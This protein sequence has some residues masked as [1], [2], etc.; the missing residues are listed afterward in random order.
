MPRKRL[1]RTKEFS[2]HVT[3]RSV[4]Q[5]FYPQ[6]YMPEI[7]AMACDLLKIITWC[8][9]VRVHA[10]VLMNNHYHLLIST[11]D[12]NLDDAMR[13]FQSKFSHTLSKTFDCQAL[14]FGTR[15]KSTLVD[16]PNYY[17]NV[18]R[19]IFQNPVR[20][21][22]VK[23]VE[24]YPWSN[25]HGLYG[26]AKLEIP[27]YSQLNLDGMIPSRETNAELEWLN[28]VLI[29]SEVEKIK[30]GLSKSIFRLGLR[31]KASRS[32]RIRPS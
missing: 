25:L 2:Y 6:E 23:S 15:Y 22:I 17:A 21:K 30:N 4:D 12:E 5:T 13:Y 1:I 20:A 31:T 18:Y 32:L 29:D 14:C 19:Y 11:P 9:G 24:V 28:T 7:W 3:N 10:F 16:N 26:F 27:T 8:Y